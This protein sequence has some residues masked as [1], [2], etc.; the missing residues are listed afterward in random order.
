M[1]DIIDSMKIYRM[2]VL[3]L[4]LTV[5][6][7]LAMISLSFTTL[8]PGQKM[9]QSAI[10]QRGQQSQHQQA[11]CSRANK[12]IQSMSAQVCMSLHTYNPFHCTIT[13]CE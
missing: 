7:T 11:A 8:F 10:K 12:L 6:V 4:S 2:V 5:Q 13:G 9:L 1:P 3:S